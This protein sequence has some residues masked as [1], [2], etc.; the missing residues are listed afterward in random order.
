MSAD[1]TPADRS[2]RE[3][4][5]AMFSLSV[6]D[7]D[8]ATEASRYQA[9]PDAI[10]ELFYADPAKALVMTYIDQLVA[11]G[12][13]EWDMLENGDIQL[14]LPRRTH[15]A[16]ASPRPTSSTRHDPGHA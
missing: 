9:T 14:T 12:Y 3:T 11:D 13:A 10:A 5:P 2:E 16:S 1:A 6:F 8:P 4:L 15:Y 7:K